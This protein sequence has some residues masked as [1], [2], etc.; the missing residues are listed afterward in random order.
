MGRYDIPGPKCKHKRE[1]GTGA[2]VSSHD[3]AQ[4]VPDDESLASVWVCGREECQEDA[5][6]WVWA[7][8]HR[9]AIVKPAQ[10]VG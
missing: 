6:E 5:E 1:P 10:P 8:T 2:L 3:L 9:R 7:S 4:P